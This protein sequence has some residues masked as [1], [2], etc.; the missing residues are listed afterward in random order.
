MHP[1]EDITLFNIRAF[2]VLRVVLPLSHLRRAL[3]ALGQLCVKLQ[4]APLVVGA[5]T[6][7]ELVGQDLQE[8]AREDST[9][10]KDLPVQ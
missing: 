9:V 2:T 10:H 4:S 3:T 1:N 7:L 6:V 8:T 5:S